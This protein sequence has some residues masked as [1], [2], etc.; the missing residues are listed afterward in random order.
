MT[1]FEAARCNADTA[2]FKAASPSSLVL[3]EVMASCTF[4]MTVFVA[5]STLRLRILRFCACRSRFNAEA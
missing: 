1:P 4:L 2:G 5:E 3:A